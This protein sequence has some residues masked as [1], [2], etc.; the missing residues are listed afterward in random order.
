MK[1]EHAQMFDTER[2]NVCASSCSERCLEDIRVYFPPVT[3]RRAV[4][5]VTAA[6]LKT[7]LFITRTVFRISPEREGCV[8]RQ[9]RCGGPPEP[10]AWRGGPGERVYRSPWLRARGAILK[11]NRKSMKG[12]GLGTS[13]GSEASSIMRRCPPH[14]I[15]TAACRLLPR[16]AIPV[17]LSQTPGAGGGRC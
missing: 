5:C 3:T 9:R 16:V 14:A 15:S 7:N 6:R 4:Y 10:D 1:T 2:R 11:Y 8:L 12:K 13:D 17:P